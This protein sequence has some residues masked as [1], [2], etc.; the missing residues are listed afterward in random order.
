MKKIMISV[1]LGLLLLA[2]CACSRDLVPDN[3]LEGLHKPVISSISPAAMLFNGAGFFLNVYTGYLEDDQYVLYINDRKIGQDEPWYGRHGLGWM[4]SKELIGEL[5]ASSTDG[6][7]CNV[8]VTGIN[9]SYDI[10]GNFEKYS[11]YVSEPVTLEIEKGDT[12]FS[13][14]RQLFPEWTHSSEPILRCDAQGNIYLAWIE[15]V[16]DVNQVFF[17]FSG[18]AGVTW[19]Q[20]LNISRSDQY[21]Y[22][23][24]LA[25]DGPG[26]FYMVWNCQTWDTHGNMTVS[27]IFFSRSLDNGATWHLPRRL[28]GQGELATRPVI[29]VDERGV[30]AVAWSINVGGQVVDALRLSTSPD[31]GQSWQSR[32]F[33]VPDAAP[34]GEAVLASRADGL[35]FLAYGGF[36]TDSHGFYFFSSSDYGSTWRSQEVLTGGYRSPFAKFSAAR[37]GCEGQIYFFWGDSSQAGHSTYNGNYFLRRETSGDWSAVQALE[38]ICRT[39]NEKTALSV[40]PDGVDVVLT[41]N[42]GLF[43]L[44]SADEGKNWSL[45][46]FI[47]GADGLLATTSPD[48]VRHPSGKTFLVYIRKNTPMDGGLY[49]TSFD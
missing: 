46:E 36:F 17:S 44:R 6:V 21:V 23:V 28:N 26:R 25:V 43:L 32:E 18:D 19:S 15:K 4:L 34:W 41:E 9:Q 16:N 14:V 8:R 13:E 31:W 2:G 47:P 27:D 20:V 40:R 7:T 10:S 48:T 11:D 39:V 49:L 33:A 38:E 22:D 24:D 37:F 30:V 29:D 1:L 5:L 45:P 3:V 35:R 42:G 12:Q